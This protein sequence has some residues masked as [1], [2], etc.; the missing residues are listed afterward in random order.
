MMFG[1][2]N[3]QQNATLLIILLI[4]KSWTIISERTLDISSNNRQKVKLIKDYF[5]QTLFL[6]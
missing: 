3:N 1:L 5:F 2:K 4:P 6:L